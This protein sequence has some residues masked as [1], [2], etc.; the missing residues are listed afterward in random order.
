MEKYITF[1]ELI[2][3]INKSPNDNNYTF[4]K[5]LHN[6]NDRA[7]FVSHLSDENYN[8]IFNT[9]KI[10]LSIWLYTMKLIKSRLSADYMIYRKAYEGE[11]KG[12]RSITDVL[13]TNKV[14]LLWRIE[15]YKEETLCKIITNYIVGK[16]IE[17]KP[18]IHILLHNNKMEKFE[19]TY[20][21]KYYLSSW[22][23]RNY[24][25]INSLY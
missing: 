19:F 14:V 2:D 8:E 13:S 10:K 24:E 20:H 4:L 7:L 23:N 3:V 5:I 6:K 25:I 22:E 15:N 18:V 11:S 21:S 17:P 1:D 9:K 16:H 12:K